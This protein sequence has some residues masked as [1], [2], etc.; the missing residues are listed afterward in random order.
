MLIVKT[1]KALPLLLCLAVLTSGCSSISRFNEFPEPPQVF[2]GTRL[3]IHHPWGM[4]ERPFGFAF[5]VIPLSSSAHGFG[6]GVA[7]AG[8]VMLPL[9]LPAII[10]DIPLT[11]AVDVATLPITIPTELF[12]YSQNEG[13]PDF[14]K[15]P[16]APVRGDL[17]DDRLDRIGVELDLIGVE[18]ENI[19]KDIE[20]INEYLRKN[21]N[22]FP[23]D[24]KNL[25]DVLK[26]K[27]KER[28]LVKAEELEL[29]KADQAVRVGDEEAA[30]KYYKRAERIGQDL[31]R[32][33]EL[34]PAPGD[35]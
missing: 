34:D 30:K 25:M 9:I 13:P 3:N 1:T 33:D 21:Q 16:E 11:L 7:A 5:D 12:W 15:E 14:Y 4:V 19:D 27:K 26:A 29:M 17:E 20:D 10:V 6:A 8:L 31:E 35:D 24:K 32:L 18:I 22:L 28:E 2:G 23:A